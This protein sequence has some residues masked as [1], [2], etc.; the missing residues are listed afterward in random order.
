ML[1]RQQSYEGFFPF[2]FSVN[3][4]RDTHKSPTIK[5]NDDAD[6]QHLRFQSLQQRKQSLPL[7]PHLLDWVGTFNLCGSWW[8]PAR[9]KLKHALQRAGERAN[10]RVL[11]DEVEC[12]I[13]EHI[14]QHTWK[15]SIL[16]GKNIRNCS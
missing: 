11:C 1:L 2:R 16:A 10:K 3:I 12:L 15:E 9:Q 4:P 7:P 6:V 13:I 14:W 8:V 5:R